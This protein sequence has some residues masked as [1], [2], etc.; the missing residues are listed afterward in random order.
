MPEPVSLNR[1]EPMEDDPDDS[2]AP[3]VIDEATKDRCS[4][5]SVMADYFPRVEPIG[6]HL[7]IRMREDVDTTNTDSLR[8]PSNYFSTDIRNA[9]EDMTNKGRQQKNM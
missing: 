2:P 8:N 6:D 5:Q 3:L 7:P 4:S 9:V 1:L